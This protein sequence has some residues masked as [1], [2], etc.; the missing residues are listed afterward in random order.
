MYR[1]L[2]FFFLFSLKFTLYVSLSSYLLVIIWTGNSR[3]KKREV[4]SRNKTV[5]KSRTCGPMER[6]T[7]TIP[8]TTRRNIFHRCLPIS[9]FSLPSFF[10]SL[11]LLTLARASAP[12]TDPRIPRNPTYSAP[13][14]PEFINTGRNGEGRFAKWFSICTLNASG[15]HARQISRRTYTVYTYFIIPISQI[16]FSNGERAGERGG[17]RAKVVILY[18]SAHLALSSLWNWNSDGWR[19]FSRFYRPRNWIEWFF[20][21]EWAGVFNVTLGTENRYDRSELIFLW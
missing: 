11:S 1:F 3:V 16:L 7:K 15:P 8:S 19:A 10:F 2:S 21:K 20:R 6:E 4:F 5:N 18:R 17:G 12:S 14:K 9:L 13:R